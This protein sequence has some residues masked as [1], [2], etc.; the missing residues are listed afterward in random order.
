[1]AG[2]KFR[3]QIRELARKQVKEEGGRLRNELAARFG[4]KQ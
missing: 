1:M 4:G 2:E 3:E